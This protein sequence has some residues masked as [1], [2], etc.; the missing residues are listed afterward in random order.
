MVTNE[1]IKLW[2][3]KCGWDY[4]PYHVYGVIFVHG[5]FEGGQKMMSLEDAK[6][7]YVAHKK[8]ELESQIEVMESVNEHNG[9][10]HLGKNIRNLKTDVETG[11]K[12]NESIREL[13]DQLKE[14]EEGK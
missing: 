8:A 14:L 6:E 5:F 10:I 13:K 11:I 9:F 4:R 1:E 7:I 3:N 12:Y 2:M